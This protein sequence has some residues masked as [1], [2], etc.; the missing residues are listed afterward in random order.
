MGPLLEYRLL[1]TFAVSACDKTQIIFQ[2]IADIA[3][4]IFSAEICHYSDITGH[5]DNIFAEFDFISVRIDTVSAGPQ[6]F[7]HDTLAILIHC[8]NFTF[9]QIF[10]VFAHQHTKFSGRNFGNFFYLPIPDIRI[11]EVTTFA[12]HLQLNTFVFV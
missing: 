8:Q 3:E 4:N 10:S 6:H 1:N 12:Q 2:V 7:P 9:G 11:A 5:N